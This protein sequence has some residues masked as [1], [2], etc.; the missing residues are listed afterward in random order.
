MRF[1]KVIY[2]P[3]RKWKTEFKKS[4]L[5]TLIKLCTSFTRLFLYFACS[6]AIPGLI[7]VRQQRK[8]RG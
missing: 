3:M 2:V 6:D 4:K 5:D 8:F 7:L 1:Y